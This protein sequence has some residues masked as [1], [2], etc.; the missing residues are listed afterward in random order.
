MKKYLIASML[1]MLVFTVYAQD[2]CP[3]LETQREQIQ[4][5]TNKKI[6]EKTVESDITKNYYSLK[7]NVD[8]KG[9]QTL[10]NSCKTY[11][12]KKD[13]DFDKWKNNEKNSP[14]YYILYTIVDEK[15]Y[16]YYEELK[17]GEKYKKYLQKEI[18]TFNEDNLNFF[19]NLKSINGD[20][21]WK[22]EDD[23][24]V[25]RRVD[26][27]KNL[28]VIIY[29]Y[30]E[31]QYIPEKQIK[32]ITGYNIRAKELDGKC[33]TQGG[34]F[35]VFDDDCIKKGSKS[36]AIKIAIHE[37]R[38]LFQESERERFN[39]GKISMEKE[40]VRYNLVKEWA[41]ESKISEDK[42]PFDKY[43]ERKDETD[44]R[45][46]GNR[47]AILELFSRRDIQKSTKK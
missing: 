20:K 46:E 21:D 5:V 37:A 4:D 1:C 2:N 18:I 28:V 33:G 34:D 36:D 24:S 26:Y 43:M 10:A 12:H 38:H 27:M 39:A 19:R 22:Q 23:L 42:L 17:G 9:F 14:E 6:S 45:N 13:S 7:L 35:I 16:V 32:D 25:S 3:E 47:Y 40:K 30:W 41:E 29:K 11:G 44:A 31:R 8:V 15:Y